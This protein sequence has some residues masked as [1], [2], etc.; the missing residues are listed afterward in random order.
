MIRERFK[1]L[2]QVRVY[3]AQGRLTMML[4]MGLP[5][6]IVITM[7]IV[8]PGFIQPLF[9]DPI[10]HMLIAAGITLHTIGYFVIRRIIQIQV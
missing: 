5:P 10:G 1:I 4:L 3:T 6:V 7:L 9:I 2:R 8:S